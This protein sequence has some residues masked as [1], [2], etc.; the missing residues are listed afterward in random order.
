MTSQNIVSGFRV[1]GICPFD[2]TVLLPDNDDEESS[3]ELTYRRAGNFR[4]GLIFADFVG[5]LQNTNIKP[6]NQWA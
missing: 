5:G 2:H 4:G 1:T 3:K 6:K